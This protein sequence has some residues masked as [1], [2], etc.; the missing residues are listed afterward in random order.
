[1]KRKLNFLEFGLVQQGRAGMMSA[2]EMNERE[3]ILL[4][5]RLESVIEPHAFRAVLSNGHGFTAFIAMRDREKVF[6]KAGDD[7][8]VEMSPANMST[9][10]II[11]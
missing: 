9:G 1:M 4:D 2:F 10:R 5:A 3:T 11:L 8:K 7:V 6:P